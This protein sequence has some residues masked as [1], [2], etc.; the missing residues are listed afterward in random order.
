MGKEAKGGNRAVENDN[1][2]RR[3]LIATTFALPD[4]MLAAKVAAE[5]GADNHRGDALPISALR[6][7]SYSTN[8]QSP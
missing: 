3:S 5:S 1:A 6:I 2:E 4:G 8:S 7:V